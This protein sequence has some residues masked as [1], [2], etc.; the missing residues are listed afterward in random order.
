MEKLRFLFDFPP[1]GV[2]S[3]R[4]LCFGAPRQ[5]LSAESLAGVRRTIAAAE[6]AAR[7]GS[8]VAGF[9]LYEA[10]P[11]FDRAQATKRA[12]KLPLAWFGVFDGPLADPR[13]PS[14]SVI[15]PGDWTCSCPRS[16]YDRNVSEILQGICRGDVYQ[17]NYTVRLRSTFAGDDLAWFLRL[18]ERQ[19]SEY[20]A[21]LNL[22]RY[23]I[24]CA[25]PELFFRREGEMLTTRPMKGTAPRGR[26]HEEDVER[27]EWLESSEK[28]RAENVM[29]VDLLRNDLSRVS[30]PH[31]V[32][33]PE[34]FRVERYPTV[35]QMTSTVTA[36]ARAGVRLDDIFAA[37][38]PCGSITGAP[39]IK[40][41]E[42]ISKLESEAREI[43]C[44]SIGLIAP[45]GDAAFNV[46]L[47]TV[48][49]DTRTGEATCGVGGGIVWES[50]IGGEYDEVMLKSRFLEPA[51]REFRLFETMRL[52]NRRYWL[53]ERHLSRLARSAAFFGF[54]FDEP[55]CRDLLAAHAEGHP[56]EKARVKLLLARDGTLSVERGAFPQAVSEPLLFGIADE[57]VSSAD[58]FLFHKTTHRSVYEKA[59]ASRPGAFDVLLWNER[60][61]L[62]EFTRGNVVLRIAGRSI[63]PP[64]SCGV[65]DGTFRRELLEHGEVE[66]GVLTCADLALANEVWFV[67]GLRGKIVMQRE[68]LRG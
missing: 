62:T 28:N 59:R 41:M 44:G 68:P 63:T 65:L 66:E 58:P 49:L 25:S 22:G 64:L 47:R 46:A 12:A 56:S 10:G 43:Y 51:R 27:A 23:R 5:V 16:E 61:E 31:S 17:V 1:G 15:A 26:F 39:K 7:K 4:P 9:V 34:L 45:G 11:A 67:N 6:E 18:R 60:G 40:A 37:L 55:A 35:L 20:C 13:L 2:E 52:E 8:W 54:R 57:P 30:M 33:V 36:V 50:T 32:R 19:A 24:L 42:L 14:A 48:L 29:I 38:F 53:L 21:Y 3:R